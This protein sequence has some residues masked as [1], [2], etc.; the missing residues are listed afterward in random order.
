MTVSAITARTVWLLM[1]TT[2]GG[3]IS[4]QSIHQ[5]LETC[6]KASKMYT[7]SRYYTVSCQAKE[8]R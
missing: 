6:E 4:V 1:L 2:P 3:V 8:P 5:T 7:N